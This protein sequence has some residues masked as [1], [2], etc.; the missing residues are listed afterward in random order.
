ME[1]TWLNINF[2]TW[3]KDYKS[4]ECALWLSS[5]LWVELHQAL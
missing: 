1:V 2:E 4:V 3:E 5:D